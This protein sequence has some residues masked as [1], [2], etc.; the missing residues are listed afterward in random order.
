M[1]IAASSRDVSFRA[2]DELDAPPVLAR[3]PLPS[4]GAGGLEPVA[5][6]RAGQVRSRG[7]AVD[8]RAALILGV[9]A[10]GGV[11]AYALVLALGS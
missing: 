11:A 9:G 6:P 7:L 10:A 1:S 4:A 3:T 5:P 2:F 8:R